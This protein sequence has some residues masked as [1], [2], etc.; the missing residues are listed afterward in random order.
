VAGLP[1]VVCSVGFEPCVA[2]VSSTDPCVAEIQMPC[3]PPESSSS[4]SSV[5]T[6]AATAPTRAPSSQPSNQRERSPS[7][8]STHR[9]FQAACMLS[10]ARLKR[11]SSKWV[12]GGCAA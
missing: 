1:G 10:K 11:V 5:A 7:S 3:V 12:S 8:S 2:Y 6:R 9:L 4:S